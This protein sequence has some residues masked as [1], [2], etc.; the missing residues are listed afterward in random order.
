MIVHQNLKFVSIRSI[1]GFT[2]LFLLKF[3]THALVVCLTVY[4]LNSLIPASNTEFFQ[5]KQFIMCLLCLIKN[6]R[7]LDKLSNSSFLNLIGKL[8]NAV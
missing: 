5:I 1:E 2:L 6:V 8:F 3:N 7:E 4:N